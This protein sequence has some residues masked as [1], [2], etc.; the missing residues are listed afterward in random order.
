VAYPDL[1]F[2]SN[3]AATVI[4]KSR[5]SGPIISIGSAIILSS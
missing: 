2:I 4:P 3:M 5:S 1:A